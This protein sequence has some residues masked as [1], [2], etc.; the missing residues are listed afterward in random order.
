MP[1]VLARDAGDQGSWHGLGSS[2]GDCDRGRRAPLGDDDPESTSAPDDVTVPV[3]RYRVA[4]LAATAPTDPMSADDQPPLRVAIDVGPLY[5]HRTGI[6]LA[7]AELVDALAQRDDVVLD[8][9]LV[10]FRS[11]PEPGH[12]RLPVP[13]IVASHLWSRVHGPR[14]DRWAGDADL[15]HGTN[16]VVPPTS[17]P[18][19]VSVYDCWF[20]RHPEQAAPLVRRAGRR[21]RSAVRH[22]AWVHTSSDATADEV[23]ALLGTDRVRT[24]HLGAPAS[25]PP[26]STLPRPAVAD[27]I[28]GRP[29]VL[30]IGTEERRKDLARLVAAFGQAGAGGDLLLVLAGSPGDAS[31]LV[32]EAIA[33]LTPELR[34]RV[35]RLGRVEESAKHWLLRRAAALAYPSLDEGFGF[36]IVEAQL[37]GTPV[38]ACDVGAVREIGGDGVLTVP[39]RDTAAL[40]GA[41][42]RTLDDGALRLGLIEAGH[43][44]ARRFDWS[45]TAQEMVA[46]YRLV[47]EVGP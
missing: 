17:L 8:P 21:L 43:R 25:P 14:V 37:A 28:G 9:Y 16:Y 15:V 5:G 47:V 13:G 6:G 38:I 42:T 36:P 30:A 22:G 32:D 12:R 2:T 4:L 10:S 33:A 20:L 46:L 44:N 41:I 7:A 11:Q 23:R 19:V 3:D 31:G 34:E 45:R 39:V 18:T 1:T 24:V 40:A 29:F 26:A 35:L 27:R